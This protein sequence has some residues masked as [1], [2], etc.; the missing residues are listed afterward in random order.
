MYGKILLEVERFIEL[1]Y[2]YEMNYC[3][4]KIRHTWFIEELGYTARI[5]Y[6]P[7]FKTNEFSLF[8]GEALMATPLKI[9]M[10]SISH[11]LGH[12]ATNNA[13]L[14]VTQYNNNAPKEIISRI[15]KSFWNASWYICY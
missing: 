1:I 12:L 5:V 2:K 10:A 3:D 7:T 9:V 8:I 11:E 6:Q 15:R 13:N 4:F 14:I